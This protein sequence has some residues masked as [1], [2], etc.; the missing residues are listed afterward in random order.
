MSDSI[1][2]AVIGVIS[3]LLGVGVNSLVN[4]FNNRNQRQH[5]LQMKDKENGFSRERLELE[6]SN[7][8]EQLKTNFALQQKEFFLKRKLASIEGA[9]QLYQA[10]ITLLGTARSL[11]R[12]ESKGPL[13][14]ETRT[15]F[16]DGVAVQMAK[17]AQLQT[18]I[19]MT[20]D[21]YIGAKGYE[22]GVLIGQQFLEIGSCLDSLMRDRR[23]LLGFQQSPERDARLQQVNTQLSKQVERLESLS[24]QINER[25]YEEIE[26]VRIELHDQ[27]GV[28]SP[29]TRH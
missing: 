19:P 17:V 29:S 26:R 7:S 27:Y 15:G 14:E 12:A 13:S 28:E 6:H 4:Y 1:L 22:V 24:K 9:T 8:L 3:A 11:V 10:V 23:I 20:H 21:L 16:Y 25:Y 18:S 5:D 2:S